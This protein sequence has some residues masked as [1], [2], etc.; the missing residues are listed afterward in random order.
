MINDLISQNPN[1]TIIGNYERV[2]R[3]NKGYQTEAELEE[4][5]LQDLEK[6][7]YQRI[8]IKSL[9]ELKP[10]LK[11]Q[12]EKLNDITFSQNE[13]ETFYTNILTNPQKPVKT[14]QKCCKHKCIQSY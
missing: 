3:K 11:K 6:Q 1:S 10:N 8:T 12:L 5:L 4:K 14:K 2:Q 9:K 13:W 7:G